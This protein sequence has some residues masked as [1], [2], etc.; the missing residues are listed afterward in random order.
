MLIVANFKANKTTLETVSWINNLYHLQKKIP[1]NNLKIVVSPSFVALEKAK[2]EIAKRKWNFQISLATQTISSFP[3]GSYTGEIA[4]PMVE[5]LVNYAIVGHSETRK[6]SFVTNEEVI[7]KL[8]QLKTS[9][10]IPIVC[11][12]KIEQVEKMVGKID[13]AKIIFAY[14]PLFAIGSGNADSLENIIKIKD[15]ITALLGEIKLL[16]GGSVNAQ[17]ITSFTQDKAIDGFLIGKACLDPN[18]FAKIIA[19]AY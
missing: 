4:V 10:I 19:Y 16:Y 11:I 17:N 9:P 14:E 5:N 13:P 3:L 7:K 2:K 1:R 8:M 6:Y 18:S 15:K 12:A